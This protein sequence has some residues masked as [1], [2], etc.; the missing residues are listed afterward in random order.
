MRRGSNRPCR[1]IERWSGSLY[2]EE[3]GLVTGGEIGARCR[4]ARDGFSL[5]NGIKRAKVEV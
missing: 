3:L 5:A 1:L 4:T 2:E